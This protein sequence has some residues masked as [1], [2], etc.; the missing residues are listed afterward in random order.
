MNLA[1]HAP[2]YL[3]LILIFLIFGHTNW[4][5]NTQL[6]AEEGHNN[7]PLCKTNKSL[8]K[9]RRSLSHLKSVKYDKSRMNHMPA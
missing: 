2:A 9:L 5:N 1:M 7:V 8:F 4:P 6:L 3:K